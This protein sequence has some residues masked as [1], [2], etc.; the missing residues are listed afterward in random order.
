MIS[1]AAPLK[2]SFQPENREE[3][4]KSE[5]K[6]VENAKAEHPVFDVNWNMIDTT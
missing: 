3:D 5:V 2:L 6:H 4:T 1:R